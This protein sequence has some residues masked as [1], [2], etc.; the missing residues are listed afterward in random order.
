LRS[1]QQSTDLRVDGV[2]FGRRKLGTILFPW[3][4]LLQVPQKE[5]RRKTAETSGNLLAGAGQG[6]TVGA[7]KLAV[8]FRLFGR[9]SKKDFQAI[10]ETRKVSKIRNPSQGPGLASA[11]PGIRTGFFIRSLAIW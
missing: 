7:A 2:D 4:H 9:K 11:E 1:R 5:N 3:R 6:R 8:P 10:D